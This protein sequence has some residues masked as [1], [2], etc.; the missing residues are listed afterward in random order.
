MF[1]FVAVIVLIVVLGLIFGYDSP[2]PH[3]VVGLFVLA[4]ILPSIAVAVRRLHDSNHSGWWFFIQLVPAIGGLWF[5]YF[6]VISGTQGPN[7]FG[8]STV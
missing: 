7:R 5:L 2:I 4:T 6:L 3:I 1:V 8:G